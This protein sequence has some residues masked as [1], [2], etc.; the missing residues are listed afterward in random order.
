MG[1]SRESYSGGL[2]WLLTYA[3]MIT[4]LLAFFI[5]LY[6]ASSLDAKKYAELASSLRVAFNAPPRAS[7][8]TQVGGGGEKLLPIPDPVGALMLQL[9]HE[10]EEEIQQGRVEIQ[11]TEKGIVLRFRE[12]VFFESGKATLSQ[13]AQRILDRVAGSLRDIPNPIEVEGHTDSLPVRTRF[14]PTNWELSVA[15]ATA[16]VR[17]LVEVRGLSPERLAA[18]GLADNRPLVAEDRLR[19]NPRNRRVEVHVLTGPGP[20]LSPVEGPMVSPV[21]AR[22]EPSRG[23]PVLSFVEGPALSASLKLSAISGQ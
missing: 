4:L 7:P 1:R 13:E 14:F 5:V 17:Y 10:L 16:V 18:R 19:G 6:V 3:D 21:E 23:G 9:S 22:P 2:R 12:A 15:R 8:I 11:Q 20:V